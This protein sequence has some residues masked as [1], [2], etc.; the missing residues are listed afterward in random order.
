[1]EPSDR[2]EA[3]TRQ[4]EARMPAAQPA[5]KSW[6]SR[7]W[8]WVT[9]GSIVLLGFLG[10]CSCGGFFM[11]LF[12]LIK[13]SEAY[14]MSFERVQSDPQIIE[15]LGTPI[16]AGVFVTGSIHHGPGGS[17]SANIAYGISGPRGSADVTVE[18][19]RSSGQW[20]L[21][22]LAVD[23]EDG[24]RIELIGEPAPP[25]DTFDDTGFD[26]VPVPDIATSTQ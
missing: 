11:L 13:N 6:F 12:G 4:S 22:S 7:N 2:S 1:M 15:T 21:I 9:I 18:A 17:G 19:I 20:Q 10:A 5:R 14:E 23:I 8:L 16:E 25:G 26:E 3:N 24:E